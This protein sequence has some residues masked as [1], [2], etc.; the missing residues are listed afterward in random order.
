MNVAVDYELVTLFSEIN[1]LPG[2]EGIQFVRVPHGI[3]VIP[4]EEAHGA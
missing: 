2:P 4:R 3:Y 1:L